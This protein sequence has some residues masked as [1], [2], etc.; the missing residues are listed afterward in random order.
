MGYGILC[1]Q[2][3]GMDPNKGKCASYVVCHLDYDLELGRVPIRLL[4][5]C[6]CDHLFYVHIEVG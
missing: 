1:Y 4:S 2:F 3:N 5:R 6:V